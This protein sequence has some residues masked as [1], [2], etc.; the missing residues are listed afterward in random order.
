MGFLVVE[1]FA[2]LHGIPIKEEKKLFARVGKGSVAGQEVHLVLPTTYMNE[3]G[4]AVRAYLDYFKLPLE[5]VLVIVDD[6]ALPFGEIRLRSQGSSGGHNGLKSVEKYL[7]S[8]V[9]SRLRMG[10]GR[11]KIDVDQKDYKG[12]LRDYVLDVFTQAEME[13]LPQVM[14]AGARALEWTL[15]ESIGNAMNRVNVKSNPDELL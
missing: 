12:E 1:G 8:T 6:V 3:S 2:R 13:K 11:E 15:A 14:D 5:S 4:R 10:I 7:G 9:Y